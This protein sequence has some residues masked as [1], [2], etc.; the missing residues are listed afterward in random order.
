MN[1][2]QKKKF[3][4]QHRADTPRTENK[5]ERGRIST[6]VIPDKKKKD[7]KKKC[8]GKVNYDG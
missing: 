1:K 2:R 8:R 4:K 5:T 3:A 6:M 7:S